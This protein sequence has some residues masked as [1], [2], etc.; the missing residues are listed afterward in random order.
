VRSHPQD[1]PHVLD[2]KHDELVNNVQDALRQETGTTGTQGTQ[3]A[4]QKQ[5][6]PD[7]ARGAAILA[8]I[9]AEIEDIQ[10]EA[11]S[12]NAPD[13]Q[14]SAKAEKTPD[15]LQRLMKVQ[16]LGPDLR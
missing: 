2:P 15:E 10:S 7:E 16:I 5:E 14:G 4:A 6:T 3:D 13:K 11:G 12:V 9:K 1:R 8:K